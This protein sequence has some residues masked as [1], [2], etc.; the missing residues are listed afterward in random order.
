ML[1]WFRRLMIGSPL[2]SSRAMQER[3][4]KIL[5]LPVFSSDAISSVGYATEEILLALIIAGTGV[6]TGTPISLYVGLAIVALLWIVVTSYRQTIYAY[7]SGGGSYIV[8]KENLGTIPGLT[9]GAS[10]MIDYVLTVSVS[11]SSGVAAVLSFMPQYQ[12][13]RVTI[14]LAVV[15]FIMLANLRGARETGAL[16][17]LPTYTFMA[18]AAAVI[19]IGISQFVKNPGFTIASPAA[20]TI[21]LAQPPATP[22]LFYFLVLRAF[23]SGCSA[24]TGTE[25]ISNGIQAFRPP[26]SKNAASTLTAMAVILSIIFIGITYIAWRARVVPMEQTAAGYQTVLSQI[27][28]ATVGRNWLYY[29]FQA[30]TAGIL[31]IAANTSFAGFPRLASI[32]ARDRFIP[33]QFYNVGDR[34]VYS[35]GIIVLALLAALL[36]IIFQGVV[37]SLIPLYAIGVFMSFTLSQAGMVVHFLRLKEPGWRLHALVSGVGATVT[38]IVALVQAITKAS[39][40]AWMVLVLIP[41]LVLMFMK[42]HRHYIVLGNQLRL[43]PEDKFEEMKN[44]VLVLTPSLH[45]GILP[46][47]EYAKDLSPDVRAI[48]V[49]T[50]PVDTALLEERWEQW[51]GGIPLVILESPYRSLLGPL[52]EY[53]EEAKRERENHVITVVIPEFV[54][55]TWWE[56]LLHNQSGFVLKFA[57]LFRRDIVTTNVRYYLDK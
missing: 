49:E 9:A 22:W 19:C 52:M 10:L 51:G 39:E 26:E 35:N 7:P 54:P 40:G 42:I 2:P 48:H 55:A 1:A 12:D 14:A 6:V 46:A 44:T 56:K 21:P 18:T 27:A 20:S 33:R 23:A 24:M 38:A 4:I 5:A 32:M 50:D 8:A 41:A 34:L 15:G 57:L 13:H 29:L 53:L 36:I 37:N 17:A 47:L 45:R 31:M 30:A 28:S 3:L 11:V 25:A 16:F 43:T